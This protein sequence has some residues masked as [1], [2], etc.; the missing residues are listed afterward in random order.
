MIVDDESDML[1]VCKMSVKICGYEVETFAEPIKAVDRF[2]QDPDAFLAVLTDIRMPKMNGID[3]ARE[4]LKIKPDAVVILM[5]AFDVD[6]VDF[7]GLATVRREDV[8]MK[9]FDPM[10]LC[11]TIKVRSGK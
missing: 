10:N 5:T 2:R 4:I 8:V 6:D 11:A 1:V 7:S 9:P 3:L